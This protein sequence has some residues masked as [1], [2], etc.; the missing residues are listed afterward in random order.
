MR[1]ILSVW[2]LLLGVSFA[3]QPFQITSK[4]F[5]MNLPAQWHQG[6]GDTSKNFM[7]SVYFNA[8]STEMLEVYSIKIDRKV[9]LNNLVSAV[10]SEKKLFGDFGQLIETKNKKISKV[11]AVENTYKQIKNRFRT[12]HTRATMFC[13]KNLGYVMIFRSFNDLDKNDS[14]PVIESSF[15]IKIPRT[16]ADWVKIAIFMG[17]CIFGIGYGIVKLI[18]WF[19]PLQWKAI[20]YCAGIVLSSLIVLTVFYFA[21]DKIG[22]WIAA[23][24]S[25]GLIF[26][27][28]KIPNVKL[29]NEAFEK[30][31]KENTAHSYRT[32]C[33]QHSTAIRYCRQARS[34]MHKLMD[35]VVKKYREL[36]K[37]SDT[38]LTRAILTM[39]E[40]VKATDNF[41]VKINYVNQNLIIDPSQVT[42]ESKPI[43]IVPAGS[44]FT[45]EKNKRREHL[46]TEVIR[47]AFKTITPEDILSFEA[48]DGSKTKGITFSIMYLIT[49]SGA[50]YYHDREKDLPYEERTWYAGVDFSWHIEIK[51]PTYKDI[52]SLQFHS[53][54]APHFKSYGEEKDAVYNAMA[55]SAFGDFCRVFI[56]QSGFKPEMMA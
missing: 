9:V 22:Y 37:T 32:F 5:T 52:F 29:V 23:V 25:A 40:Y 55:D 20:Y 27:M 24:L 15:L 18:A 34:L 46:I 39:F 33:E 13:K 50:M 4:Y 8:D 43:K 41:Q 42:Y 30:A 26:G 36:I 11:N 17:I 16:A 38:P 19:R 51:V 2:L 35:A 6:K 54:P 14:L 47:R 10:N 31:K 7:R 3:Q 44:A 49:N 21:I 48:A 53:E 56:E 28:T 12:I 45:P 1:Q